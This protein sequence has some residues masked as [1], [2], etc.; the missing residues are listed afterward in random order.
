MVTSVTLAKCFIARNTSSQL[1]AILQDQS[2]WPPLLFGS[3][4]MSCCWVGRAVG[5]SCQ[6]GHMLALQAKSGVVTAILSSV[7]FRAKTIARSS[8]ASQICRRHR[9]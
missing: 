5:R 7:E 2:R 4:S 1:H 8:G 9:T 3:P 6:L